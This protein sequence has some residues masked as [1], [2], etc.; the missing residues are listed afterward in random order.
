MSKN[1][2]GKIKEMISKR[3]KLYQ[4]GR[5]FE[6]KLL[7][8]KKFGRKSK[9]YIMKRLNLPEFRTQKHGGKI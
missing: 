3:D 5:M 2:S 8:N 7:R 1:V 6:Y 4:Q 9:R